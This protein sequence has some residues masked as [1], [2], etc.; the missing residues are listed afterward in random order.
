MGWHDQRQCSTM[1]VQKDQEIEER[2]P[3]HG[4]NVLVEDVSITEE[5]IHVFAEEEEAKA[6]G[7]TASNLTNKTNP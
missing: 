1:L 5:K 4:K 3:V 2:M 7:K 6:E